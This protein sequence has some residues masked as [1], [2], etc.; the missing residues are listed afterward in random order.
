MNAAKGYVGRYIVSPGIS[1]QSL[2][3]LLSTNL[4]IG[5]SPVDSITV[6]SQITDEDAEADSLSACLMRVKLQQK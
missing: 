6:N 2:H 3:L 1:L 5:V 4:T